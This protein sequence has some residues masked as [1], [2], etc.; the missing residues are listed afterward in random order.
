[1]GMLQSDRHLAR[2][3]SH[4]PAVKFATKLVEKHP[5]TPGITTFRFERPGDYQFKPG[6][7]FVIDI[8]G[9]HEPLT[10]H[11]THSSSPTEPFLEFTTRLTG[12]DFKNTLDGLAMGTEVRMEGPFGAFTIREGLRKIAFLTGGIGVTPVRSILR[13]LADGYGGGMPEGLQLTILFGNVSEQTITFGDELAAIAGSLPGVRLVNIL[14]DPSDSWTG[15]RGRI[16]REIVGAELP[17]ASEWTYYVSGPPPMVEAMRNILSELE[18]PRK[19][20]V[21]ENFEGYAS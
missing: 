7:W 11:F 4:V 15:H 18:I 5:R 17:D 14:S 10:K 21:L 12:S 20:M 1:M 9:S 13:S 19:Q 2:R 16:D 6:Q 3:R 8:P